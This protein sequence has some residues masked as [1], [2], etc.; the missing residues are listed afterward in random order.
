[1]ASSNSKYND[2]KYFITL[3][4]KNIK[5]Y[6]YT[7][8]NTDDIIQKENMVNL[9]LYYHKYLKNYL[10]FNLIENTMESLLYL[11]LGYNYQG[12]III[13]IL[14][15][16]CQILN[17]D[18]TIKNIGGNKKFD[19]YCQLL[20]LICIINIKES[21]VNTFKSEI[22]LQTMYT[23]IKLQKIDIYKDY[24]PKLTQTLNNV[25]E[26]NT[27]KNTSPNQLFLR[28][29]SANLVQEKTGEKSSKNI[30]SENNEAIP[31]K[32]TEN[33]QVNILRLLFGEKGENINLVEILLQSVIKGASDESLKSIMNIFGL[34]GALE[35]T[36]MEKYFKAFGLSLYLS[37]QDYSLEE[38][39][40]KINRFNPKTKTFDEIDLS[41][42]DISTIQ[43]VVSLMRILKENT[44]KE[45]STQIITHLEELIKSLSSE[46][47]NLIDIILPKIIEVI[48]K[49]ELHNQ[50]NLF[51]NLLIIIKQFKKRI[52]FFL[53]DIINLIKNY[54][55]NERY[56]EIISKILAKLFEEFVS[57]MEKYFT[58]FIPTF[59]YL[60]KKN[61]NNNDLVSNIISLLS[62]L[63]NNKNISGYIGLILE[64]L[65]MIYIG[66]TDE[67]VLLS[68]LKLFK[69]IAYLENIY[70][71]YPLIIH[72]LIE[73][74]RLI[75]NP[76]YYMNLN[77]NNNNNYNLISLLNLLYSPVDINKLSKEKKL[78]YLFKSGPYQAVNELILSKSLEV[79]IAMG[80]SNM[81]HFI[82][83]LPLIASTFYETGILQ[84]CKSKIKIKKLLLDYNDYTFMDDDDLKDRICSQIC[85]T[86][87]FFGY[88]SP[89]QMEDNSNDDIHERIRNGININKKNQIDNAS[90]I[91]QFNTSYISEEEDWN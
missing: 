11:M 48:P 50:K 14:K 60:M 68:F 40:F 13:N 6:L 54:I 10:D 65:C 88:Y 37:D 70:L 73:K 2:K 29:L 33:S 64:E 71:F 12:N 58:F 86:N 21:A 22:S 18:L 1:M 66:S 56:F 17:N 59:L 34:C 24:T 49:F 76:K 57:E 89:K 91:K 90:I 77:N 26:N 23:I 75:V 84:F 61:I 46:E 79:F 51:G 41:K 72:T 43:A 78:E 19:E 8:E 62:L 67:K 53:D 4:R 83:F 7:I 82:S 55:F 20:L 81:D 80:N 15:V 30:L 47:A 87:C 31:N 63:T 42:I 45:L 3:V 9:L 69:Q 32:N 16:V 52:K 74:F 36:Q 5:T 85:K 25:N 38:N 35:P 39:D 27:S 28:K 44:Q